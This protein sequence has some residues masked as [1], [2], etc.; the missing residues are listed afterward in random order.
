MT[1]YECQRVMNDEVFLH[2]LSVLKCRVK[3]LDSNNF[4]LWRS[5][6]KIESLILETGLFLGWTS[7]YYKLSLNLLG[8]ILLLLFT[9][10]ELCD[11]FHLWQ[12]H[13]A[14]WAVQWTMWRTLLPPQQ[15]KMKIVLK[16]GRVSLVFRKVIDMLDSFFKNFAYMEKILFE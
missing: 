1:Q 5:W 14:L 7:R 15:V 13:N 8:D 2:D 11:P 10:I 6:V 16:I 12:A 4:L 9:L 3:F